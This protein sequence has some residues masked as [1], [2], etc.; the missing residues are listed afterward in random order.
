MPET[1]RD[2]Y[3][4]KSQLL[5]QVVTSRHLLHIGLKTVVSGDNRLSAVLI[6]SNIMGPAGFQEQVT[7]SPSKPLITMTSIKLKKHK[8]TQTQ[9]QLYWNSA[10]TIKFVTCT[11]CVAGQN[12]VYEIDYMK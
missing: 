10:Q 4:N 7:S 8:H 6:K 5:H 9:T 2:I 11:R 3:N 12:L 1:C